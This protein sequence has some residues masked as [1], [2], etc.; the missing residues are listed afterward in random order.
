MCFAAETLFPSIILRLGLTVTATAAAVIFAAPPSPPPQPPQIT[1]M[2][3][4]VGR[5]RGRVNRNEPSHPSP[6]PR[7]Y[8]ALLAGSSPAARCRA[9]RRVVIW[10]ALPSNVTPVTRLLAAVSRRRRGWP[11]QRFVPLKE[12]KKKHTHIHTSR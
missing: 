11:S 3:F 7:A 12:E 10:H 2:T 6:G 5:C 4:V 8:A 9:R 1:R